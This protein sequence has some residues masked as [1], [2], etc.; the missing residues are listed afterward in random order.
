MSKSRKDRVNYYKHHE[1]PASPSAT[2]KGKH[3]VPH[4]EI[5]LDVVNDIIYQSH[6]ADRH[7]NNR[8]YERDLKTARAKRDRLR[9][10]E[11][12]AQQVNE[13]LTLS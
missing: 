5:P 3:R 7:G 10:Q 2:V 13:A 11:D 1:V 6:A 12:A 4:D 9:R 8:Q